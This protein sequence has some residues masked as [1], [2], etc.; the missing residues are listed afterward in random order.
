M[1]RQ[2]VKLT[3]VVLTL[4]LFAC[5]GEVPD[6]NE[7]LPDFVANVQIKKNSTVIEQISFELE[8]QKAFGTF[9]GNGSYSS[10]LD[11]FS[12]LVTASM[13]QGPTL[14]IFAN[15]GGVQNGSHDLVTSTGGLN[16]N[17]ATLVLNSGATSYTSVS[18]TVKLSNTSLYQDIGVG[19]ADYFVDVEV[20]ISMKNVAD[21][22]DVIS[23]EG[24]LKGVNIKAQ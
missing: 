2:I 13:V 12:L 24:S 15:T 19:A 17:F 1:M 10:S 21:D 9:A 14:N 3:F 6:P 11:L 23:V 16:E 7:K 20:N 22:T 5:K 8:E 4:M 18:G